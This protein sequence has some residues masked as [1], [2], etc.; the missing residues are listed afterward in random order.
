MRDLLYCTSCVRV[1]GALPLLSPLYFPIRW[2]LPDSSSENNPI[3]LCHTNSLLSSCGL[4]FPQ[5]AD[6]TLRIVVEEANSKQECDTVAEMKRTAKEF[7]TDGM[8]KGRGGGGVALE[9]VLVVQSGK[10]KKAKNSGCNG[11]HCVQ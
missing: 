9:Y 8:K 7:P 10:E 11:T 1:C 2:I 6:T 4:L 3:L 5:N